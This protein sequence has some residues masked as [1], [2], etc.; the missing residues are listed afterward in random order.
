ME[1]AIEADLEVLKRA[2]LEAGDL[3]MRFFR[4]NPASWA[5]AGGSP[6]TEADMAVDT[7][8]R[9]RLLAERPEYAWLSEETADTPARRSSQVLFVVDPIDG[10]RGFMEG[11]DRWCVSLAVVQNGRPVAAVLYAAARDELFL[12]SGGG[13]A[14]LGEQRLGVSRASGLAGSRISGPRGWMKKP[15]MQR[16]RSEFQG[17]VPSLAYRF[18]CVASG[19][20]D[21]AFASPRCYD[22]DLA[23]CDLLVHEAGGRLTGPDG[24]VPIYNRELP[25]HDVLAAA[26]PDLQPV[27]LAAVN[28][29]ARAL[30]LSR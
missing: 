20:F 4:Q 15:A 5:K 28:E 11:D 30:A 23:A 21:G 10:T 9:E 13:G 1:V 2:A 16:T 26:N 22:W 29:T 25:R 8:L 6:V 7:L 14:W 27:L 3:A 17:H 12:A 24:T 18:A 19:R